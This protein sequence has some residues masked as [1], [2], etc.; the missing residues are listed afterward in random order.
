MSGLVLD[1]KWDSK[2]AEFGAVNI[3]GLRVVSERSEVVREFLKGWKNLDKKKYKAAGINKISAS[4]ALAY[5][6]VNV[7][8]EAFK[9]ILKDKPYQFRHH[10]RGIGVTSCNMTSDARQQPWKHGAAI[11]RALKAVRI[12]GLT[13]F[14]KYA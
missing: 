6:A 14:I 12:E 10:Q 11:A 4:G 9:A 8:G 13:G 7:L 5:D 3:T 1:D 2:V